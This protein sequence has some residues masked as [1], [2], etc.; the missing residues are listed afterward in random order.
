M[1][2]M[3]CVLPHCNVKESPLCP[4]LAP[5]ETCSKDLKA[6]DSRKERRREPGKCLCFE[7]GAQRNRAAR[8]PSMV[9]RK[10]PE[11]LTQDLV[12]VLLRRDLR[13]V[14]EPKEASIS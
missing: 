8:G 2:L 9:G 7:K 4:L 6:G 12:S 5:K 10:E 1:V 11:S 13:Q 14:T 3:L